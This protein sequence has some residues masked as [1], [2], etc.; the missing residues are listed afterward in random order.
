MGSS[1]EGCACHR[2]VCLARTLEMWIAWTGYDE[3]R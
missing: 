2:L 3:E 1:T